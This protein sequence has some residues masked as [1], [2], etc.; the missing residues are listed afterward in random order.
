MTQIYTCTSNAIES[1]VL[2][3][4]T[5]EAST[6]LQSNSAIVCWSSDTTIQNNV[7]KANGSG[8]TT[9]Y[10]TGITGG[11]ST[12]PTVVGNT[13]IVNNDST[14][15]TCEATAISVQSEGMIINGNTITVIA[16]KTA[17]GI[18]V[19]GGVEAIITNNIVSVSNDNV[20]SG[21]ATGIYAWGNGPIITNNTFVVSGIDASYGFD[22][23]SHGTID[24]VL[25]TNNIFY[26]FTASTRYGI[27]NHD[28]TE[29]ITYNLIVNYTATQGDSGSPYY[30]QLEGTDTFFDSVVLATAQDS[31]LADGDDSNYHLKSGGIA[32]DNG[33]TTSS[34]TYDSVTH[35]RDGNSRPYGSTIYDMGAYEQGY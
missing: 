16:Q 19:S 6:T 23:Y 31:L 2:D 14:N 4:F 32:V 26:L 28:N 1:N 33:T 24:G 21:T 15:S 27:S 17:K 22:G 5:I 18:S 12:K 35:D 8:A 25:I 29:D 30:N 13:F 11:G 10:V 7:I 3:G 34:S 20:P 9:Q